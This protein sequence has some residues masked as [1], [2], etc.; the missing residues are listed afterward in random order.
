MDRTIPGAAAVVEIPAA[1]GLYLQR[2]GAWTQKHERWLASLQLA[3]PLDQEV[4]EEYV[5]AVA[6]ELVGFLWSGVYV[7]AEEAHPGRESAPGQA[8]A[9]K[10]PSDK[11]T[12]KSIKDNLLYKKNHREKG[13]M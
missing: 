10:R 13:G 2:G 4:F 11:K 5:A 3:D 8:K 1:A 6:R 9:K 7:Q 12:D